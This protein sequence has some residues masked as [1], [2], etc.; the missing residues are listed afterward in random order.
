M[1]EINIGDSVIHLKDLTQE[2]KV[3]DIT[4][5]LASC[6]VS[7]YSSTGSVFWIKKNELRV[8]PQPAVG[9][10]VG[11]HNDDWNPPL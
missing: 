1:I 9:G 4:G 7:N 3:L 6:Q 11:I 2:Y 8:I 5:D 10:G